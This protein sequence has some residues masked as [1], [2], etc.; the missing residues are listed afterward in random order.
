V[1]YDILYN[2]PNEKH[3]SLEKI[4]DVL[5]GSDYHIGNHHQRPFEGKIKCVGS[6][7]F[8]NKA[9]VALLLSRGESKLYGVPLL[10][11]VWGTLELLSQTGC[12]FDYDADNQIL[13]VNA[14]ILTNSLLSN[15]RCG[16]GRISLLL[17]GALIHR[18]DRVHVPF[19]G[20]DILGNRSVDFHI[21]ALIQFGAIV[22]VAES[23]YVITKKT[24]LKGCH[25]KLPY[26][27]V[28]ATENC[29]FL[30]VLARGKSMIHN[31][32]IEPE[33]IELITLLQ[34]MG[35]IIFL[36]D[37]R[38]IIIEG[39]SELRPVS[40]TCLGDRLDAATW[41]M[42]AC[43][44]K[45][46]V[47]LDN[48][49]YKSLVNFFPYFTKIGGGYKI[50]DPN[51]ISFF[52]AQVDMSPLSFETGEFPGFSTDYQPIVSVGLT[53]A[54]G[55]SVVH[56]TVYDNRMN[57]WK[58]LNENFQTNTQISHACLGSAYCR[59]SNQNHYHSALITGPIE[60]KEPKK[61][62]IIPDLRAGMTYVMAAYM[63]QGTVVIKNTQLIERGYGY[64]VDRL[65]E[66]NFVIKP[67]KEEK[68]RLLEEKILEEPI[69]RR[70]EENFVT[71]SVSA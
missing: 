17:L 15:T 11:D 69:K 63:T 29:L 7:N 20:G 28:M 55:V 37:N 44:T 2:Q 12:T 1:I 26:P 54:K 46:H 64:L 53:Q 3:E 42:L 45:G 61:P 50:I 40:F 39:V 25:V 6:K 41:A 19:P 8:V 23:G 5:S 68:A 32:A 14:R 13:K 49:Q 52:R 70:V 65:K 4:F 18:F 24:P 33:I 48:I 57:F 21:N 62:V 56:E 47:T 34:S 66:T 60:F 35:A 30:G 59:F 67:I 27:S 16:S 36:T 31:A 10:R 9:I 71:A 51:T 43:M 38:S 22:E 58:D